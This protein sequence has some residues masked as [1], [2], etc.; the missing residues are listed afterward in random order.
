VQLVEHG[1][2]PLELGDVTSRAHAALVRAPTKVSLLCEPNGTV[3]WA[4][5]SLEALLGLPPEALLGTVVELDT[6]SST[7]RMVVGGDGR[8]YRVEVWTTDLCDD[9]SVRGMLV[10]WFVRPQAGLLGRDPV[11]GLLTLTRLVERL[12][13][14]TARG[15]LDVAVIRLRADRELPEDAVRHLAQRLVH[16]LRAADLA[17]R[18]ADGDYVVVC[19]G[20]WTLAGAARIAQR[21]RSNINGPVRV[22]AGIATIRLSAGVATGASASLDALLERS[23]RDLIGRVP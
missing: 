18:L 4:S 20:L 11:T 6:H 15:E 22:A 1:H 8:P 21:L 14:V 19:P 23:Q 17:G 10:E 16:E 9:P 3:I 12:A 5:P 7:D 13:D 2:R